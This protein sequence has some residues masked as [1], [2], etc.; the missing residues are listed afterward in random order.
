MRTGWA[1][2][3][4]VRRL[5]GGQRPR[6]RCGAEDGAALRSFVAPDDEDESD[7]PED[8]RAGLASLTGEVD[9]A[10]LK[11]PL[12]R[13]LHGIMRG[14]EVVDG[15]VDDD[16]AFVRPWGFDLGSLRVPVLIRHG[17]QD[18]F[19]PPDHARWLASHIPDAEAWITPD[20]GHLT[21]YESGIPGVHA[22]LAGHL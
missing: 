2:S 11:G 5:R 18:R 15:W 22:W 1:A 13:Y 8:L 20:D 3:R 12:L 17:E 4:L 9:A 16:L 6:V 10:A 19:V 7:D 14:P 21:L